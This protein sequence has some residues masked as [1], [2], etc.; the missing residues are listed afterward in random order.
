LN[1]RH[2]LSFVC[3]S[4][5]YA[6]PAQ[7]TPFTVDFVKA[8]HA[9]DSTVEQLPYL[10]NGAN[11]LLF[12]KFKIPEIA[13]LGS[14]NSFIINVLLADSATLPGGTLVPGDGGGETGFIDFALPGRNLE[15]LFFAPNLNRTTQANPAFITIPLCDCEVQEVLSSIQDGN[16]RIRLQRN[17]GGLL[18][19][20]RKR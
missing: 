18:C 14:I 8:E 15:L 2:L 4:V 20:W 19:T 6:I 3:L 7:A 9:P 12:L 11:D 16:F 17:S 10:M 5:L 1:L 13:L